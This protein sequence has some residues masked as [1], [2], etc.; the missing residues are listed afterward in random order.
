MTLICPSLSSNVVV[1]IF[2]KGRR[3]RCD[4]F[5]K[6]PLN[7]PCPELSSDSSQGTRKSG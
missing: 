1:V 3:L 2:I 6:G 5:N 7:K 4:V